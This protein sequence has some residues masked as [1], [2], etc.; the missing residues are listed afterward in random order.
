MIQKV[1]QL[2]KHA[3]KLKHYLHRKNLLPDFTGGQWTLEIQL[4][5]YMERHIYGSSMIV[6][7]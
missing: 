1:T 3:E 5:F 2:L 7:S 4:Q 6:L